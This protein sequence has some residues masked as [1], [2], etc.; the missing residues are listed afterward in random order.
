MEI[1]IVTQIKFQ[2]HC[3]INARKHILLLITFTWYPKWKRSLLK[4]QGI[5]Q[6]N[7]GDELM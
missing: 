4:M 6:Y 3:S 7:M 2:N 1:E 5:K